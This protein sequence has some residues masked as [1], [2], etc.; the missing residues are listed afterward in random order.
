MPLL[1]LC[2]KN[3]PGSPLPLDEMQ[4]LLVEELKIAGAAARGEFTP[5]AGQGDHVPKQD[6]VGAA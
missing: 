5:K 2:T 6:L 3:A 4:A 1:E